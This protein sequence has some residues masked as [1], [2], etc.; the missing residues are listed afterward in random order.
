MTPSD[1]GRSMVELL[2]VLALIGVLSIGG[3][4]GY[5][6]AMNRLKAN[7]I[8]SLASEVAIIGMSKNRGAGGHADLSDL[9]ID[10]ASV[11]CLAGG[12]GLQSEGDGSVSISLTPQGCDEVREMIVQIAASKITDPAAPCTNTSPCKLVFD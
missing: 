6:S 4:A 3:I 5:T 9:N 12:S 11:P 8:I 2:G 1:S 10:I 7:N